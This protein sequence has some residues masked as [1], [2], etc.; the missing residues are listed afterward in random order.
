MTINYLVRLRCQNLFLQRGRYPTAFVED[1][2]QAFLTPQDS[3][4]LL[5]CEV[6]RNLWGRQG[7]YVAG[8]RT[9]KAYVN[10]PNFSGNG[11]IPE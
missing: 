3:P 1:L 7:R 5:F 4:A 9:A 10:L 11:R 6:L 8:M 2:S